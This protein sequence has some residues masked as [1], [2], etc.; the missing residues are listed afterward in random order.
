VAKTRA[1]AWPIPDPAP[2]MITTLLSI[3]SLMK[4][5]LS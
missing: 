2:V 4:T 5:F 1:A 3:S